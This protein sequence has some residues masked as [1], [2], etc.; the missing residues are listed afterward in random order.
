[1]TLP[2]R[3]RDPWTVVITSDMVLREGGTSMSYWTIIYT[4]AKAHLFP[5]FLRI[6]DDYG[7]HDDGDAFKDGTVLITSACT[8]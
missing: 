6:D 3:A 7:G 2:A 4:I 1:M 5:F 8:I